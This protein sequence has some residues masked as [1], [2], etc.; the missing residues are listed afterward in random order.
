[1]KRSLQRKPSR[2][3]PVP[4]PFSASIMITKVA[5]RHSP[6]PI[7]YEL[8]PDRS[9]AVVQAGR[10]VMADPAGRSASHAARTPMLYVPTD[11][12]PS[13]RWLDI[14]VRSWWRHGR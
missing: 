3:Q 9:I 13:K 8:T 6:R 2:R 1:M 10:Y 14:L 11:P 4:A 5:T 12:V 7:E